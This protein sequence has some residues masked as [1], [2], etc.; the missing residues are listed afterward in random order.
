M[1][2]STAIFSPRVKLLRAESSY[3]TGTESR[4]PLYIFGNETTNEQTWSSMEIKT[5]PREKWG[6]LRISKCA[7]W[8]LY[9]RA[10][11]WDLYFLALLTCVPCLDPR[12]YFITFM[13][14]FTV[15]HTDI[16]TQ[17]SWRLTFYTFHLVH[18][19]T[20]SVIW[21]TSGQSLSHFIWWSRKS[22][23]VWLPPYEGPKN[24]EVGQV[25]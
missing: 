13:L 23:I 1:I 18:C 9:A 12:T 25:G 6:E 17:G 11:V 19:K 3:A 2:V 15:Q 10:L 22:S 16:D 4:L 7:V 8:K 5:L 24:P 14:S 20:C 21:S